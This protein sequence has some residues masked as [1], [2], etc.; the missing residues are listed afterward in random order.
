MSDAGDKLILLAHRMAVYRAIALVAI[1][2]ILRERWTEEMR[3]FFRE[4]LTRA[5]QD[6]PKVRWE[7]LRASG[8][9]RRKYRTQRDVLYSAIMHDALRGLE[10]GSLMREGGIL[11]TRVSDLLFAEAGLQALSLEFMPTKWPGGAFATQVREIERIAADAL[12]HDD[13]SATLSRRANEA[14]RVRVD[15]FEAALEAEPSMLRTRSRR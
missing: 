11:P 10:H 2:S 5:Y 6:D 14:R 9:P 13:D 15:C 8:K 1:L 7:L 3:A 12:S 4:I